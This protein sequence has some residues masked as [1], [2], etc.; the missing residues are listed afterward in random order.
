M[1]QQPTYKNEGILINFSDHQQ[2][3]ILHCL[4]DPF[5]ILLESSVEMDLMVFINHGDIFICCVEFLS[6]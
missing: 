3:V 5:A 6:F 4:E 1:E 2:E